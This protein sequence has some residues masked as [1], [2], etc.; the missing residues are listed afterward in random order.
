MKRILFISDLVGIGGGE[1]SLLN[2]IIS[3]KENGYE[4][5]V[6]TPIEGELT[7]ILNEQKIK[8]HIRKDLFF[9]GKNLIRY[10]L[11]LFRVIAYL[12][13]ENYNIIHSNSL[14]PCFSFG[15]ASK[16]LKKKFFYTCHGQWFKFSFLRKLIL[17]KVCN[18]IIAVSRN[19]Y[20]SLISQGFKNSQICEIYLGIELSKFK[21][22]NNGLKQELNIADSA[23]LIGVVARFQHI[24]GQ[25]IYV[26]A[27]DRIINELQLSICKD[28]HFIFVGDNTFNSS[29]DNDYKNQV[30]EY[31]EY[32]NLKQHISLLGERK[33]I[34]YI[35]KSLDLLVVPSRNESFGMVIIEAMASQTAVIASK[36]DG[37][38]EIIKDKETGILFEVED[39][40]ELADKII[41]LIENQ[42][43]RNAIIKNAIEDVQERFS[44]ETVI[45]K[46]KE[47]YERGY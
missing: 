23:F 7:N 15:I 46:Y 4:V 18:S 19:V 34:P 32:K 25:D 26:K 30:L 1:T 21:D 16:S 9:Q 10:V 11:T 24:K 27:I 47:L 29:K 31:L 36:C 14:A 45:N 40:K 38:L 8:V 5:T 22:A 41:L 20:N 43:A 6:L 35:M 37:P 12:M 17:E 3:L 13:K 33:D 44:I 42:E 28:V 39:Y 2:T